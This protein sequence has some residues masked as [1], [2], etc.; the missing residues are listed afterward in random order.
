MKKAAVGKAQE[1]KQASPVNTEGKKKQSSSV[2]GGE[3]NDSNE[4]VVLAT[5]KNDGKA[6]QKKDRKASEKT[7]RFGTSPNPDLRALIH[8]MPFTKDDLEEVE[9]IYERMREV[10]RVIITNRI[11]PSGE[12]A[13]SPRRVIFTYNAAAWGTEDITLV[14]LKHSVLPVIAGNE[15]PSVVVLDNFR[16]HCTQAV[17]SFCLKN[18]INF[19][20]LPP[21]T[22]PFSQP[23]DI[24]CNKPYKDSVR[25]FARRQAGFMN[26]VKAH[27]TKE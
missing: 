16:G 22:T 11:V 21:P 10:I 25:A 9:P 14:W 7:M 2:S 1:T 6:A 12:T 15:A 27:G 18:N 4:A 23:L 8:A 26:T 13:S 24:G 5:V 20:L 3:L 17:E 19:L